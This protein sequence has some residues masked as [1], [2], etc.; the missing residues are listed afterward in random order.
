VEEN[1]DKIW[2]FQ[3]YSLIFKYKNL[4][5]IPP[6]FIVI[7]HLILF[8]KMF[9]KKRIQNCSSDNTDDEVKNT[10][11]DKLTDVQKY[12]DEDGK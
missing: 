5:I 10:D 11:D 4:P 3:R 9:H 2:K 1:T 6:P 7:S 12:E 8:V